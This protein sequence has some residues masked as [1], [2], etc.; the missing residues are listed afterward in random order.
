MHGI[1]RVVAGDCFGYGEQQCRT[2]RGAGFERVTENVLV[3]RSFALY[4]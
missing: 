4:G 2:V 3:P 1:K